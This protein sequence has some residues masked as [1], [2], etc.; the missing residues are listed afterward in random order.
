MK[1]IFS[2]MLLTGSMVTIFGC[3]PYTYKIHET[4][5]RPGECITATNRFGMIKIS[6]VSPRARLYQ[7]DHFREKRTLLQ[8]SERWYGAY[9]IYD[10]ADAFFF[11]PKARL[12]LEEG[13][14]NF[15]TMKQIEAELYEGS[16]VM[17]WVYTNDGLVLG[18]GRVPERGNQV[19]VE[20]YQYLLNGKKPTHIAGARP[21][22]M[23]RE[24]FNRE[25]T[26]QYNACSGFKPQ[27]EIPPL[28]NNR[29]DAE[30]ACK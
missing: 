10:P 27:D 30:N 13:I 15:R 1:H 24:S 2:Q 17:D 9:G 28:I 25:L 7:W 14:K 26:K 6:Y 4:V 11:V 19:N 22:Q 5:L 23:K 20:L 18:F 8:R 3:T 29:S 16:A 21:R 12:V